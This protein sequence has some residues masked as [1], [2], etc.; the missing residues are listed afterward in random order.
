MIMFKNYCGHKD[1]YK[2][3]K[4][5]VAWIVNI[6]LEMIY[7]SYGINVSKRELIMADSQQLLLYS[8][9]LDRLHTN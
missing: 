5:K 3:D 8:T 7:K 6:T 9:Q 2:S 1:F 4:D